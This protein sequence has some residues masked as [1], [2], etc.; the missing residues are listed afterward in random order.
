M[1]APV[2]AS[3]IALVVVN[4]A[5]VCVV[6]NTREPNNAFRF[7]LVV[8]GQNN[9]LNIKWE[10]N[11]K[12]IVSFFFILRRD[13]IQLIV[14]LFFVCYYL[15]QSLQLRSIPQHPQSE[16]HCLPHLIT[17]VPTAKHLGHG[18]TDVLS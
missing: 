15:C 8:S 10:K 7:Q 3:L 6:T 18:Q 11:G 17:E 2:T 14:Y 5:D 1:L 13:I 9:Y 4:L 12:K 16:P